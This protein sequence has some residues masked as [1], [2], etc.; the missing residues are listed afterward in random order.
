MQTHEALMAELNAKAVAT[1]MGK[2]VTRGQLLEAFERVEDKANWKD[3]IDATVD[4]ANDFELEVLRYAIA[5][6]TGSQATFKPKPGK[7]LL[8]CRYRVTAPGYY[9]AVGA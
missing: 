6:F 4:L 9:R 7:K 3:P 8:G 5:F 2:E 1:I